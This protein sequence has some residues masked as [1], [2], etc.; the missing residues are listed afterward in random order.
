VILQ[1]EQRQ[2]E[3]DSLLKDESTRTDILDQQLRAERERE[4]YFQQQERDTSNRE[5]TFYWQNFYKRLDKEAEEALRLQGES[6]QQELD[7]MLQD[8]LVR[9]EERQ[10]QQMQGDLI[11][12]QEKQVSDRPGIGESLIDLEK[13]SG[14]NVDLAM[15]EH[16]QAREYR[17]GTGKVAQS[18]HMVPTSVV[19]DFES[20]S[21]SQA[22]TALLPSEVHKQF[23]DHWK[24]WS[25]KKVAENVYE[26][27]VEEFLKV[28]DEAAQSVQELRGRTADTMHWVFEQEFY[29]TLGLEPST[30]VRVPYSPRTTG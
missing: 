17:A 10:T 24:A 26:V 5:N 20:Y 11:R 27:T 9:Q 2:Q 23:D 18:A 3:L 4:E 6:R 21:R 1:V 7:K 19:E 28:L 22:L 30:L 25:R 14:L 13:R 12:Q 16:R 29:Q 8:A 15:Q